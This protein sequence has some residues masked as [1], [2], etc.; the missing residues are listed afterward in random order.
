MDVMFNLCM[1]LLGVFITMDIT[2]HSIFF[3]ICVQQIDS[4][5]KDSQ[6]SGDDRGIDEDHNCGIDKDRDCEI[7][8]DNDSTRTDKRFKFDGFYCGTCVSG[9][10][11]DERRL[12][13]ITAY[14][15]AF[16]S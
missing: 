5:N 8:A 12:H 2:N 15:L 16:C 10:L 6:Y 9:E 1:L 7:D 11:F 3:Y 13:D 14:G 4:N